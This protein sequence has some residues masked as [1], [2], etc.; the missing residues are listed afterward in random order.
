MTI[1]R[2]FAQADIFNF[3]ETGLFGLF[4]KD[5]NDDQHVESTTKKVATPEKVKEESVQ[6]ESDTKEKVVEGI[7]AAHARDGLAVVERRA[8]QWEVGLGRH[9][10]RSC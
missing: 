1:L 10:V 8:E 6:T 2:D 5:K 9:D 7:A 4:K 3:D